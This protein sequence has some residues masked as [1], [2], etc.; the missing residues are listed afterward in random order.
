[1]TARTEGETETGRRAP[2]RDRHRKPDMKRD[3]EKTA[4][5]DTIT[6]DKDRH[7][8]V[9]SV[10]YIKLILVVWFRKDL[11]H[12]LLDS[13]VKIRQTGQLGKLTHPRRQVN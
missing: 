11:I 10:H 13:E 3:R 6:R 8:Q 12:K 4:V 5:G 7:V 2:R 1:M 9:K